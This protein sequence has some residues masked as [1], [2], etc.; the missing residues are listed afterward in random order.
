MGCVIKIDLDTLVNQKNIMCGS[1]QVCFN[2]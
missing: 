1:K 2:S